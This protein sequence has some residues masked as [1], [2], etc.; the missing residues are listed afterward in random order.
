LQGQ[1]RWKNDDIFGI[2]LFMGTL[3]ID[4]ISGIGLFMG[5]LDIDD[6]SGI[7]LFMST[8]DIAFT[9]PFK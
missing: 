3:D 4:D 7:G 9:V 8:L 2:G 6:I 5:T 1:C